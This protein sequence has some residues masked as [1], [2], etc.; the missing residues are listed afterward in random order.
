MVKSGS[1]YYAYNAKGQKYSV[2]S[3]KIV[4]IKKS[5]YCVYDKKGRVKRNA[6]FIV[7]G[8][9][10]RAKS[11]GKLIVNGSYDGI[12]FNSK[13]VAKS[14][15]NTRLKI[16][17]MQIAQSKGYNLY[18]CFRYVAY[19]G[20]TYASKYPT[21]RSGWTR[22]TAYDMLMTRRGNCYSFACA[23]AALAKECGYS[24]VVVCGR[25]SGSRDGAADGLTRHCWVSINGRFY[26]PEGEYAGFAR[27]YYGAAGNPIRHQVQSTWAF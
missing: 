20:F 27:G 23:F 13:G 15:L 1:Y 12:S 9:L 19:G 16:K 3:P 26:D 4:K 10:Y 6:W 8:K 14:S 7:K 18:A 22:T 21:L 11:N 2:S 5:Y 25:I 17:A 24:P